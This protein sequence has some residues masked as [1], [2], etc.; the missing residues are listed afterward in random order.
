MP[1]SLFDLG[2][3]V[4]LVTGAHRGIGF[5]IAEEMAKAGAAVAICS[6]DADGIALAVVQLRQSGLKVLGMACDVGIDSEL[7]RLVTETERELGPID[8]LVCNAGI[9]PHFGPTTVATDEE[10]DAIMRI[11]LRSVVQLT[12]RVS[13]G[14]AVR[15]DGAIILTSSLSGLRGN[16]KIGVYALSKAA[17][18]QH[19]R[20]LAVE[21]GAQNV[22]V[23]AISPGLIRTEF[24][25]PILSNEEGLQR[26]LEKTPLKRV[27]EAREI[28]GAAVFLAAP[29]GAFVTGH[30]LVVDGGTL[31]SDA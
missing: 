14:M 29:A 24:A 28:A 12:N 23:N 30:N 19:A 7:D 4:A 25:T 1:S 17:L 6:N 3:K 22:R 11:N 2:G 21:L 20:N 26:R 5:A 8:I 10:Y 9:N 31:I 16:A 18:A 13:P 27:G 15:R